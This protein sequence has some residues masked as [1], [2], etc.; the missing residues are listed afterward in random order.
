MSNKYFNLRAD[1]A[2]MIAESAIETLAFLAF[3]RAK[4]RDSKGRFLK[5]YVRLELDR[6]IA[7][8]ATEARFAVAAAERSQSAL[9]AAKKNLSS[10]KKASL[11]AANNTQLLQ[12][13]SESSAMLEN[14]D[15]AL[16]ELRGLAINLQAQFNP[17]DGFL[18]RDSRAINMWKDKSNRLLAALK[19]LQS[20]GELPKVET[21]EAYCDTLP[22][23]KLQDRETRLT[24]GELSKLVRK[25][26][27]KCYE[28][29]LVC[30]DTRPLSG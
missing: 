26:W 18:K 3:Q 13:V 1:R 2:R 20:M 4:N 5:R 30:S 14:P 7:I 9:K 29:G 16:A 21:L 17:I 24:L 6:A 15:I 27:A 12:E 19:L 8:A 11:V 25:T 28:K 22:T 23:V 10:T